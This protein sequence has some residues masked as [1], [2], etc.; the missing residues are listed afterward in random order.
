MKKSIDSI[1]NDI[2]YHICKDTMYQI[3]NSLVRHIFGRATLSGGWAQK[4]DQ[5]E[6]K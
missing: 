6:L 5:I 1:S 3:D 4:L 2:L